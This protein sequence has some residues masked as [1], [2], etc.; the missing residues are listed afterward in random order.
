MS[1]AVL[2]LFAAPFS[3]A[4]AASTVSNLNV[5]GIV[6][7]AHLSGA[8]C[9]DKNGSNAFAFYDPNISVQYQAQVTD[10]NGQV[11]PPGGS[12]SCGEKITLQCLPHQDSDIYWFSSGGA[13]D[14][15]Y[16]SWNTTGSSCTDTYYVTK[17]TNSSARIYSNLSLPYPAQNISGTTQLTNCTTLADG[18]SMTCTATNV[19][20]AP[21]TDPIAFNYGSVPGTFYGSL[22]LGNSCHSWV[23]PMGDQNL[24]AIAYTDISGGGQQQGN[25][26]TQLKPNFIAPITIPSATISYPITVTP[27][28]TSSSPQCAPSTTTTTNNNNNPCTNG[29]CLPSAP[30][31]TSAGTQTCTLNTAFT[32]NFTANDPQNQA[33]LYQVSW[34]GDGTVKWSPVLGPGA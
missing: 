28:T 23:S 2:I 22:L 20:T 24:P 33:I 11:I 29:S 4:N 15:P 34:D 9:I 30:S 12:V 25:L 21:V 27:S 8:R 14:S 31:V 10:A 17:D 13:Y 18:C 26:W 19:S 16:G 5:H 6:S 32:I 3:L 1:T 7:C